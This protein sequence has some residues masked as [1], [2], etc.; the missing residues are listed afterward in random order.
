MQSTQKLFQVILQRADQDR[1][2]RWFDRESLAKRYCQEFNL[3]AEPD[4][5]VAV[6]R[7]VEV[8]M[9][10]ATDRPRPR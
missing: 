4:R 2:S 1:P 3:G 9:A 6:Y 8:P 5:A 10:R 7:V